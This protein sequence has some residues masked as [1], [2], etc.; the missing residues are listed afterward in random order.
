M[1]ATSWAFLGLTTIVRIINVLSTPRGCGQVRP[2]S[3]LVKRPKCVPRYTTPGFPPNAIVWRCIWGLERGCPATVGSVLLRRLLKN[4]HITTIGIS[5]RR[6]T[7][8]CRGPFHN[9][10]VA[11]RSIPLERSGDVGGFM[12]DIS[13]WLIFLYT[14]QA[15]DR[16]LAHVRSTHAVYATSSGKSIGMIP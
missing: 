7:I 11:G 15:P 9:L 10:L 13:L 4:C 2:P 1:M 16:W 8:T 5:S 3:V 12:T 14:V 6:S